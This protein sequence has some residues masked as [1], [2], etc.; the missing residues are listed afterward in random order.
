MAHFL[1]V[2]LVVASQLIAGISAQLPPQVYGDFISILSIDGGAIKG[3]IP[4]VVL[5]HLDKALKAK[6]KNASL[7]Q[8]FDVIAGTSTG[9]LITA[10]LT[11]PNPNDPNRP[12]FTPEE[13]VQ[14]YKENGP[15]IFNSSRP[16][17]GPEFDG[18]FLR[19][20]T[21]ELLKETRLNETLTNVV[22]PAMDIKTQKPVI[23]SSYKVKTLTYLNAKLS[24]ICIATSAAPTILPPYYFENEDVEFNVV[25][26]GLA[27]GNPTQA[28]LS[29]VMRQNKDTKIVVL[30]L[31]TGITKVEE[32][33]N[34]EM[35]SKWINLQWIKPVFELTLRASANMNENYLATVFSGLQPAD[36]YLR[37]QEYDLDPSLDNSINV[38][39]ENLE[40][41]EEAGKELLQK[42]V[43]RMNVDTFDIEETDEGTFAEAL[44]RFADILYEEKKVRLERK[45]KEKR[46]RPFIKT[47][48]LPLGRIPLA[49]TYNN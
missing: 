47:I 17:N 49:K 14:F 9:G 4:S 44:E 5:D 36:N 32:K 28:A 7:A 35:A 43:V 8:Y 13:I 26:G 25:D 34:V 33:Y 1:V 11:A 19:N 3:I 42:N 37:V 23:F 39:K 40:K 27:A 20:I 10:M 22:I 31:G 12:A 46:G 48:T 24:D 45:S 38:T 6:D 2:T 29:E 16:G 21:R 18:E 41:L 30:S 15:H